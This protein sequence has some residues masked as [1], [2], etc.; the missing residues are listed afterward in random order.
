MISAVISLLAVA[1]SE[2]TE[3]APDPTLSAALAGSPQAEALMTECTMGGANTCFALGLEQ[4]NRAGFDTLAGAERTNMV[5]RSITQKLYLMAALDGHTEAQFRLGNLLAGPQGHPATTIR[6]ARS[7]LERAADSGHEGAIMRLESLY[8]RS[9]L[10]LTARDLPVPPPPERAAA[11]LVALGSESAALQITAYMS[12]S[13]PQCANIHSEFLQVDLPGD[14]E[15]GLTRLEIRE[16]P[17]APAREAAL[18]GAIVSRCIHQVKGDTAYLAFSDR[19]YA[20]QADWRDDRNPLPEFT[21]AALESG[22]NYTELDDCRRRRSIMRSILHNKRTAKNDFGTDVA[23]IIVMNGNHLPATNPEDIKSEYANARANYLQTGQAPRPPEQ[24]PQP[25][26]TP[27]TTDPLALNENTV[28]V[29]DACFQKIRRKEDCIGG[30]TNDQLTEL[31][32]QAAREPFIVAAGDT[33]DQRAALPVT[34]PGFPPAQLQRVAQLEAEAR[35]AYTAGEL[36]GAAHDKRRAEIGEQ[37]SSAAR[38]G[39]VVAQVALSTAFLNQHL[40]TP[41]PRPQAHAEQAYLWNQIAAHQSANVM[42]RMFDPTS[43][44]TPATDLAIAKYF[45]N[46]VGEQAAKLETL[47]PEQDIQRI[48]DEAR[49]WRPLSPSLET[50]HMREDFQAYYFGHIMSAYETLS[51]G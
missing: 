50:I 16:L 23:P 28:R 15:D 33:R 8:P 44:N 6:D 34:L 1:C 31:L 39:N 9:S 5:A 43:S 12:Y 26:H 4:E 22:T 13:C 32:K 51:E 47:L 10:R 36:T 49:R 11:P 24:K 46:Q 30:I 14:I 19:L 42:A 18:L 41:S 27:T 38:S 2:T 48:R 20:T 3:V 7:W 21:R 40:Y 25:V 45:A 37:I 29:F 35:A 17:G